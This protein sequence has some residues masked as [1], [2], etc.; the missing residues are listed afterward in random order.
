MIN[1]IF[2]KYNKTKKYFTT[3]RVKKYCEIL[4]FAYGSVQF[5][6]IIVFF[7]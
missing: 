1:K 7:K 4:L 2:V 3:I 5:M 6:A